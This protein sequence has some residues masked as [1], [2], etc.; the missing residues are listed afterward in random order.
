MTKHNLLR[1]DI[2]EDGVAPRGFFERTQCAE[3]AAVWSVTGGAPVSRL[4]AA[5]T[6]KKARAEDFTL[7]QISDS[8]S[9]FNKPVNP[10]VA[11]EHDVTGNDGKLYLVRARHRA[12]AGGVRLA[13]AHSRAQG[14]LVLLARPELPRHVYTDVG[15]EPDAA[16]GDSGA[17]SGGGLPR[18]RKHARAHVARHAA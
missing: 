12:P 13:L 3:T 4:L 11:G 6:K 17:D 7:V 8:H 18:L 16:T 9:G 1:K 14:A 2:E 5:E 10:D 15:A